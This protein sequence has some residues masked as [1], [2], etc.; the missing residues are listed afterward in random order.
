MVN[1]TARFLLVNMEAPKIHILKTVFLKTPSIF[2][3]SQEI[4]MGYK[5]GQDVHFLSVGIDQ[6]KDFDWSDVLYFT[7][8]GEDIPVGSVSLL[9][10]C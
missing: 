7:F 1:R 5:N 10:L 8:D 3:V 2:D 4:S 9:V 6:D